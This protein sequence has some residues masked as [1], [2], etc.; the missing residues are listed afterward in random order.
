MN[1][2]ARLRILALTV[3]ALTSLALRIETPA[4]A[5]T[6]T[7]RS[8][9]HGRLHA[10]LL[11]H[12]S[13]DQGVDADVAK[14]DAT[15]WTAPAIPRRESA[16]R[17]LPAGEEVTREADGGRFGGALRFR[18][19]AGP[20]VFYKAPGNFPSPAPG[21]S[22]TVSFWLSTDPQGDLAEGYCDP[23]QITSKQWDDASF[24]VEFEKRPTGIPFRLGVYA[25]K[26]VWNPQGRKFDDIP[27]AERP[28]TTVDKPPFVGGQWTHVAFTFARFNSGR[29]EGLATLY[30]NGRPAGVIS[31]RTQTFTWDP[32]RAAIML[33]LS[34]LGRLDD[35]SIFDR[36]LSD[37]EIEMLYK[38]PR[39]VGG[40]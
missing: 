32:S 1:V 2:R 18:K 40:L 15:L 9:S 34:Y 17:G 27:P 38:L 3:F 39:G 19:S 13:F 4:A 25:D 14:G 30:L 12:A 33:G 10:A 21:W 26:T 23:I 24:F 7:E 29:P 37:E 20:M 35:L 16:T 28:L 6:P 36:A 31:D 11:F 22:G 5:Q 8:E